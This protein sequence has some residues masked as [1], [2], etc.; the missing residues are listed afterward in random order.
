MSSPLKSDPIQT[1]TQLEE[2]TLC[3]DLVMKV[4]LSLERQP[5]PFCPNSSVQLRVR[6]VVT[7]ENIP[8]SAVIVSLEVLSVFY[9][10]LTK[11]HTRKGK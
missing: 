5:Q 1:L 11:P 7:L 10:S 8:G 2:L 6:D 9:R 3:A 4:P